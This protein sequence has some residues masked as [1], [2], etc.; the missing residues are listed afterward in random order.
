ME[1]LNLRPDQLKGIFSLF[2]SGKLQRVLEEVSSSNDLL[3]SNGTARN[4]QKP[5]E[6]VS[7]DKTGMENFFREASPERGGERESN[8]DQI[9][10]ES[11]ETAQ[12]YTARELLEKA[13][14]G[15]KATS[16]QQTFRVSKLL[17]LT[18]YKAVHHVD[19]EKE[20]WIPLINLQLS[21]LRN[22]L[23]N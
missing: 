7:E 1:N 8:G 17:S 5:K 11:K 18:F 21:I 15:T 22:L 10:L 20:L 16:A 14:Q 3:T 9:F 13:K 12:N 19:I 23:H 4:N 2:T 6:D